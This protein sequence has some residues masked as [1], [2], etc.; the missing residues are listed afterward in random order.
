MINSYVKGTPVLPDVVSRQKA[1]EDMMI[2]LGKDNYWRTVD[3][4]ASKGRFEGIAPAN[5]LLR[6]SMELYRI[7]LEEFMNG[8]KKGSRKNGSLRIMLEGY[9]LDVVSFI[10]CKLC[11]NVIAVPK[12]VSSL[13]SQLVA[14]LED[15]LNYN[16][17]SGTKNENGKYYRNLANKVIDKDNNFQKLSYRDKSYRMKRAMKNANIPVHEYSN[18]EKHRLGLFL[19]DLFI[20]TTH[21]LKKEQKFLGKNNSPIYVVPTD[22]IIDLVEKEHA[23]C[24]LLAPVFLPMICPP[25]PWTTPINGGY[26]TWRLRL[27]R[28]K[29]LNYMEELKSIE[30]PIVYR[31]VN[32]IQSTPYRINKNIL[33]T[34]RELWESNSTLGDLPQR[35]TFLYEE[36]PEEI[37]KDEEAF[38]AH[39][40]ARRLHH[41]SEQR[42][43]SKR[44]LVSQQLSVAEMFE[45]EP[46]IYFPHSLDWRGRV[47]PIPPALNPQGDDVGKGLL[48]FANGKAL[49]ERGAYWLKIHTAN[50]F[51]VSTPEGKKT[52]KIP[53]DERVKWI[54]DNKELII[55]SAVNPLDGE[56]FWSKASKPFQAL[57]V[58]FEMERYW[59]EGNTMLSYLP[60]QLDGS[61]NGVQHL[62]AMGRDLGGGRLVNLL[63]S[64][65]PEDVYQVV[66]DRVIELNNT[67][68]SSINPSEIFPPST[69]NGGVDI[70]DWNNKLHETAKA[71]DGHITRKI[72]KR[73]VM[74]TP[75]G[76]STYGRGD[77][78][79]E[80][81][82]KMRDKGECPFPF[83]STLSREANYL[84]VLV[85]K[86][87]GE[88]LSSSCSV[89]KWLQD[90]AYIATHEGLPVRWTTPS[91]F[92]AVQAYYKYDSKRLDCLMGGVRIQ[93]RYKEDTGNLDIRKMSNAIS[94]NFTHSLDA[95]HLMLTVCKCLDN[96]ITV[97]SMIHDSY[98]THACDIDLLS[99][100]LRETFVDIYKNNDVL[101][102]FAEEVTEQ[103][104]TKDGDDGDDDD[105]CLFPEPLE[106]GELD[107]TEVLDSNY[108]FA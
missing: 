103:L 84:A 28:D 108:F 55:D 19:L 24:E 13:S 47:Y 41:E 98:G 71:W 89:M 99:R 80:E 104:T 58:C 73:P 54:E 6:A 61:N 4:A 29:N 57:A 87:L 43:K 18:N 76:V 82:T 95:S 32:A 22:E 35:H 8:A 60:I 72:V 107:I 93:L 31:A 10:V 46:E 48:E 90:Y 45:F 74:T 3:K 33:N 36:A 64:D 94:P 88:L 39:K 85:T 5:K 11:L 20:N 1:L 49:G 69:K 34:I 30:M 12:L 51:S 62:A 17:F 44:W 52:D 70:E 101:G 105:E 106:L 102:M 42:A 86:A 16:T 23:R 91:G 78:I 7:S 50:V 77:Q 27:V 25:K 65:S 59:R 26:L 15:E 37:V 9:N 81:L 14:Y 38:K 21:Y 2:G 40:R 79:K 56:R 63:S 83:E 68:F 100:L 66:C 53:F 92:V 97:F 75:Y 67:V 96:G